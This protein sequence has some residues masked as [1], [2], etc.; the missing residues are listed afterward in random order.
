[1]KIYHDFI[2][3]SQAPEIDKTLAPPVKIALDGNNISILEKAILNGYNTSEASMYSK[4]KSS[5]FY[6]LMHNGITKVGKEYRNVG[7]I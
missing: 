5:L 4:I 3:N 2:V 6:G 7:T 1:M